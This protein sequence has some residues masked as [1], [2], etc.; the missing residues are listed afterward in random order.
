MSWF[1]LP[2]VLCWYG[3]SSTLLLLQKASILRSVCSGKDLNTGKD[4]KV[5]AQASIQS[6]YSDGTKFL[7]IFSGS[8]IISWPQNFRGSFVVFSCLLVFTLSS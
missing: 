4:L 6:A 5:E 1:T 3:A 7:V 8:E 2:S